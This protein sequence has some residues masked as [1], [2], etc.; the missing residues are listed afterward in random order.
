MRLA[1]ASQLLRIPPDTLKELLVIVGPIPGRPTGMA[2]VA[3]ENSTWLLTIFGMVGREPPADRAGG[4]ADL[5]RLQ[6]RHQCALIEASSQVM[7]H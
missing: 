2:L 3:Q 1:Y 7:Q 5:H 6:Q 4:C